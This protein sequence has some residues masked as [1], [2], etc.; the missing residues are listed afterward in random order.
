M[1]LCSRLSLLRRNG[2]I[3]NGEKIHE[4]VAA[5]HK[6]G[7]IFCRFGT[8]GF[9]LVVIQLVEVCNKL[10]TLGLSQLILKIN[11]SVSLS[12]FSWSLW[13]SFKETLF[14]SLTSLR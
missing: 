7:I 1:L 8:L 11:P 3:L 5:F 10:L 6:F 14:L 4:D 12:F 9:I 2:L 13:E